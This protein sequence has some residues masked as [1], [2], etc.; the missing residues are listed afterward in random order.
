MLIFE[1]P[2]CANTIELEGEDL[3]EL[4]CDDKEWEC[5]VCGYQTK[6]GWSAEVEER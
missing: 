4:A 5:K 1:C 6:I 3:P 2:K